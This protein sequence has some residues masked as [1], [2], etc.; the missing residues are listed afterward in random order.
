MAHLLSH[1]LS[2]LQRDWIFDGHNDLIT[3]LWLSD[4]PK[5]AIQQFIYGQLAGHLD[6]ARCQQAGFSGG[7]FA[8][9]LPPFSYVKQHHPQKLQQLGIPE[10]ASDFTQMQIEQICL[11]QLDIAQQLA[12]YSEHVRLCTSVAEIQQAQAEQKLAMVLHMEGAECLQQSSNLLD[13]F[14]D[15][16]LRSIGILWNRISHFGHGLNAKF[17]HSPNTGAGLTDAGKALIQ[18]CVAKNMLIDV[19]HMN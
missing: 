16:G 6:L 5:D 4:D 13:I 10:D 1:D 7:L 12:A 2:S 11:E 9:F 15:Q 19:S 17:P 8:I 18:Q 14:Y 3:R